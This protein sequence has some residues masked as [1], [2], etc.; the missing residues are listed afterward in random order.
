M[1]LFELGEFMGFDFENAALID[2]PIWNEPRGNQCPQPGA[3]R[4]IVVVVIIQNE[5]SEYHNPNRWASGIF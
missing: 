1:P 3:R 5:P 4:G 2:K